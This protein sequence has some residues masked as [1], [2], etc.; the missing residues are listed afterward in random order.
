MNL[1]SVFHFDVAESIELKVRL[2]VC[3]LRER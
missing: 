3:Q 2:S 1:A